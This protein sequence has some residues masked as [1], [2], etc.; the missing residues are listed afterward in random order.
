MVTRRSFLQNGRLGGDWAGWLP[1]RVSTTPV[2]REALFETPRSPQVR[3]LYDQNRELTPSTTR[4]AIGNRESAH[5]TVQDFLL[6]SPL[7]G[8]SPSGYFPRAFTSSGWQ[9]TRTPGLALTK[10]DGIS[11]SRCGHRPSFWG[12][13]FR[14]VHGQGDH[15]PRLPTGSGRVSKARN[16]RGKTSQ[17][18]PRS[19]Q[20]GQARERG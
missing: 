9:E 4:I 17:V 6:R 1:C 20:D 5:T 18:H 15:V 19:L 14:E 3:R 10:G 11:Q 8:F 16:A 12:K 2:S 13:R 7:V